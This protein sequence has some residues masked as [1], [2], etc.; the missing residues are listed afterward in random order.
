[1]NVNGITTADGG[2]QTGPHP[3]PSS[4]P[5]QHHQSIMEYDYLWAPNHYNPTLGSDSGCGTQDTAQKQQHPPHAFQGHYP[6]SR[7]MGSSQQPPVTREQYWGLG[8]PGQQQGGSPVTIRYSHGMYGV[9]SNQMHTDISPMQH[10]SPTVLH[11]QQQPPPQHLQPQQQHYGMV[12]NGVP[13]YQSQHALLSAEQSEPLT[14]LMPTAQMFT[15][16]QGCPQHHHMGHGSTDGSMA[17]QVSMMSPSAKP[18]N[19]SSQGK[20]SPKRGTVT[21]SSGIQVCRND[22]YQDVDQDYSG[23]KRTSALRQLSTSDSFPLNAPETSLVPTNDHNLQV[24]QAVVDTEPAKLCHDIETTFKELSP[25]P[26][27]ATQSSMETAFPQTIPE[28]T[29]VSPQPLSVH[30]SVL[31]KP[32]IST[33]SA[34]ASTPQLLTTPPL[35]VQTLRPPV[36]SLSPSFVTVP[37]VLSTSISASSPM[38]QGSKASPAISISPVTI[39]QSQSLASPSKTSAVRHIARTPLVQNQDSSGVHV[40]QSPLS[41]RTHS[42]LLPRPSFSLAPAQRA[43][44]SPPKFPSPKTNFL[45]DTGVDSSSLCTFPTPIAVTSTFPFTASVSSQKRLSA[46]QFSELPLV[47]TNTNIVLSSCQGTGN[48]ASHESEQQTTDMPCSPMKTNNVSEFRW[49]H[50]KVNVTSSVCKQEDHTDPSNDALDKTPESSLSMLCT[51]ETEKDCL[52]VVKKDI[53]TSNDQATSGKGNDNTL[54]DLWDTETKNDI[55]LAGII[56]VNR[57]EAVDCCEHT[58]DEGSF[59]F[60][61]GSINKDLGEILP[62]NHQTDDTYC[63]KD[64]MDLT[65]KNSNDTITLKDNSQIHNSLDDTPQADTSHHFSSINGFSDKFNKANKTERK[66][67]RHNASGSGLC[68]NYTILAVA[69]TRGQE[70]T[71]TSVVDTSLPLP[72]TPCSMTKKKARK[73]K[74]T[75]GS[76]SPAQSSLRGI[77]KKRI[78][79]TPKAPKVDKVKGEKKNEEKLPFATKK[80][81]TSKEAP[82]SACSLPD[83]ASSLLLKGGFISDLHLAHDVMHPISKS[84]NMK[85]RA[86]ETAGKCSKASKIKVVLDEKAKEDNDDSDLITGATPRRRIAT[87]EQVIFPLLH[88]W[89]RE[90]RVRKLEDRLKGE[91]WY[92]TPCGRRMKQFPEVIKYLKRHEENLKGVT[93]EHFSFSPRMPVGDFY[94]ERDTPEGKK[95][96]LLANEEVPSMIMAITGRRGRPPNPDKKV[97]PQSRALQPKGAPRKR[98]GR[99]PKLKAVDLLSKIDAR[100]LKRLEAKEELTEEDKVKLAKIKKKMKKKARMKKMEDANKR[101]IRQEKLKAKLEKEREPIQEDQA[102][103]LDTDIYKSVNDQPKKPGYRRKISVEQCPEKVCPMKRI[104]GARSKAKAL[105]KAEAEAEAQAQAALAAKRQAERRAQAK[106]RLEERKRQQK[107]LE[108]LK[109]PT[110]DMCLTDHMPLPELSHIPGL[111]LSGVTFSHCITVVEFLHSFGKVLGLQVPKDIPCLATLQE[112]LLGLGKSQSE[113]LD[114]LVN[115][116]NAVLHDPGLPPYYQS[117]KILGEKLVDLELCHSTVSEVLRVFL[118]SH[119]FERNICNSLRTKSFQTLSPEVKASILGFLVEELNASNTVINE[120][121]KT[122]EN[123]TT[124]KK[125]KWIIEGKLRKMKAVLARKTGRSEEQLRFEERRRSTR[126]CVAEDESLADSSLLENG[127]SRQ[128]KDELKICEAESSNIAS[129]PELERQIDKLT[130]RQEFFRKKLLQSSRC[131]RAM[132]LGQDRYHRRYWLLP[133]IG[134]VLVEGPEEILASGDILFMDEP[135]PPVDKEVMSSGKVDNIVEPHLSP[136]RNAT[137]THLPFCPHPSNIAPP[138]SILSPPD[139]DPL[140]GEASLMSSPRGWGRPRKIR[141]EVELHLRALKNRR[142]RHSKSGGWDSVPGEVHNSEILDLTQSALH[143]W[144]HPSQCSLIYG[145][146]D[147]FASGAENSKGGSQSED[148]MKEHI[149]RRQMLPK[150]SCKEES[151]YPCSSTFMSSINETP[152]PLGTSPHLRPVTLPKLM[153]SNPYVCSPKAPRPGRRCRKGSGAGYGNFEV[154]AVKRRGR[155]P[156]SPFQEMEQKYFT[157]LLVKPIPQEMVKGWWWIREPEELTAILTALHPRG[158]REKVLRKNLTKHMEFLTKCCTQPMTDPV[159]HLK[160][161]DDRPLLEAVKQPW[162]EQKCAMQIDISILQMVED[163]EHRMVGADLQLKVFTPPEPDST[164][165]DLQYYEHEVDPREDWMVRSKK[166]WWDL[167]RVP[168]NP[169]DLA[170][171]RLTNLERNIERR[172]LKAPLWNLA[173]VM[174]LVPLTSPPGGEEIAMDTISLENEITPRLRTWRQALD[175]CRSASQL[176]LCLLQLERAIAWEKSIIK[177]TCQVCHKGDNDAC[178]LLCDGCDRGWHMFCLRP[179]VTQVPEGDWFCPTCNSMETD[180]DS[181]PKQSAR[182][183]AKARKRHPAC[184]GESSNEE[185]RQRQNMTT[186]QKYAFAPSSGTSYSPSKRRRMATRNQPDLTYCEIILME[187]EAHP[188]AWPFLEPVNPRLVPGYRRIIKNPMDFQTMRERLLQGGYCTCEEFATDAQLIFN[189]CELFNEDTSEVGMAGHSMRRFFENRWA[190]FYPNSEK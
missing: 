43:L 109:K 147:I 186:R 156:S 149:D 110:E 172:Y 146:C 140:P 84:E 10:Q 51:K 41:Q 86:K 116:V 29:L 42:P 93:R 82:A 91:T 22:S 60:A 163:L 13:C 139:A 113:L 59:M 168:T 5:H 187:M 67:K 131:M 138:P 61:D 80:S 124:Y 27:P 75:K 76:T 183:K 24:W 2:N 74:T 12:P 135:M 114:L 33:T 165:E 126:V 178:L 175:R 53:C 111:V 154:D 44:E 26:A 32:G 46:Q 128:C 72:T 15:P 115:L 121:D 19:G 90:I 40:T 105:A 92:Y 104:A 185:Q 170:V 18:D 81:K 164:R 153:I 21:H 14:P 134:G 169:L 188:D 132:S 177:V 179:K 6:V 158:I 144:M 45:T 69:D 17:M 79:S 89:R 98:P 99:P 151:L 31:P 171:I 148:F 181:Q 20:Q 87:E 48:E 97:R 85:A 70:S 73:T 39:S 63:E 129:I 100:L 8:T 143:S 176:S 37:S 71:G 58:Q 83:E 162:V 55:S 25:T 118:E 142:R 103:S 95:W 30:A 62:E 173:E 112:G 180:E 36:V 50:Y 123:M 35:I 64:A 189:N 65:T 130:K 101:K 34:V 160:V 157:E 68:V 77:K 122:L 23:T 155:P 11:H 4:Y 56:Y 28:P 52:P 167:L 107:I 102:P 117:V 49:T 150:E 106:R 96:F 57:S 119:G 38:S 1:M 141:P 166:E 136:M 133:N 127:R 3:P 137:K 190:E 66:E 159:F 47:I 145:S 125:N 94:E 152:L 16:L 182:Q 9:Y 78:K 108:E 120:I 54:N 161:E 174:R 88:G 184:G 7:N